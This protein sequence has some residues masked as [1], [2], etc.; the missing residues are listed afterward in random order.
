M[1]CAD[2]TKPRQLSGAYL[3]AVR[4][5]LALLTAAAS[6]F[7]TAGAQSVT[8]SSLRADPFSALVGK[9]KPAA[10]RAAEQAAVERFVIATDDRVFLFQSNGGEGRLKFLCG[11]GDKRLSCV[12]DSV[13]PA[14]EIHALTASRV[15]RGDVAWRNSE[16]ETLLRIAAYGGVT[17]LWPGDARAHAASKSFGE[18]PSLI[19][20]FATLETAHAR[21]Q[22]ATALISARVGAP[23]VFDIGDPGPD[24]AGGASV[25]ADA[26]VRAADGVSRVAEDPTGARVIAAK[27]RQIR[28]RPMPR[29]ALGIEKGAL[30]VDYNPSG[31][32]DGRPSSSRI[33]RFLEESL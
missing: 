29:P 25:L 17:V 12:I 11:D 18:D 7:A 23:I 24:S 14:E 31:D 20:D 26:V 4:A 32:I 1:G 13:N 3:M 2:G 22:T 19:L 30:T 9:R 28:F 33:A 5:L 6:L 15:S 16:G 27:I 10:E 8:P 21:A